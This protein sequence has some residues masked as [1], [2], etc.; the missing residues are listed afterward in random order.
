MT[1]RKFVVDLH[2]GLGSLTCPSCQDEIP[3]HV[4]DTTFETPKPG[5]KGGGK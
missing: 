3:T 4:P 5:P 2:H 1:V